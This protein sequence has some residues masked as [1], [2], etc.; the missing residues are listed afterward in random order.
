[1]NDD[2]DEDAESSMSSSALVITKEMRRERDNFASSHVHAHQVTSAGRNKRVGST[3][4]S[5]PDAGAGR[6]LREG[7][8]PHDYGA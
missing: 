1:M 5:P 3:A 8:P 7:S 4:D 6:R 2:E